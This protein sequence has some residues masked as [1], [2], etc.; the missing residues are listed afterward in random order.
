[1]PEKILFVED[2][3][4]FCQGLAYILRP[5]GFEVFA[6]IYNRICALTPLC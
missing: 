5:E 2:E 4:G 3:K 6:V 1:M